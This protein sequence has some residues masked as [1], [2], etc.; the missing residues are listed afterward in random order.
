VLNGEI[1][2]SNGNFKSHLP[3]GMQI[4]FNR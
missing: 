3:F 2:Y 1:V 4:E